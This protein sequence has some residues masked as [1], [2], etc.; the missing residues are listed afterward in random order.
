MHE[1]AQFEK[2]IQTM[3]TLGFVIGFGKGYGT[4]IKKVVNF[5]NPPDIVKFT[6]SGFVVNMNNMTENVP[7]IVT[8]EDAVYAIWKNNSG[9]LAM[10][11]LP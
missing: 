8:F 6:D 9:E 2:I 1:F 5:T 11:E 10:R 4:A 3:S 7:Y